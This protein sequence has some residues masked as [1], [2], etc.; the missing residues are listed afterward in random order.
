MTGSCYL[1]SF[2][3]WSW[4][5]LWTSS[6]SG[7]MSGY[8]KKQ[9]CFRQQ[10][11]AH[12][13]LPL[14]ARN[15][16]GAPKFCSRR[17]NSPFAFLLPGAKRRS[18]TLCPRVFRMRI[19]LVWLGHPFA[20]AT[21]NRGGLRFTPSTAPP[22]HAALRIY[23]LRFFQCSDAWDR[24][25]PQQICS[26]AKPHQATTCGSL[27]RTETEDSKTRTVLRYALV[28]PPFFSE[29]GG[30]TLHGKAQAPGHQPF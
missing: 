16:Q 28:D 5:L 14:V 3:S 26:P 9:F 22:L 7:S 18:F 19:R 30:G 21:C 12:R 8:P 2:S 27:T 13:F 20:T 11:T 15:W 23:T 17:Q 10:K 6:M 24:T 29:Q 4:R 25:Y 1:S